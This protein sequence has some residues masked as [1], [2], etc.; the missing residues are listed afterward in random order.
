MDI[1]TALAIQTHSPVSFYL[2]LPLNELGD[3]VERISR[4]RGRGGKT[5]VQR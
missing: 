3:W 5:S 4:I 2:D 1:A